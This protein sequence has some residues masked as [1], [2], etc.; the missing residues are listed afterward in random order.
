MEYTEEQKK[1]IDHIEEAINEKKANN[2]F[3]HDGSY[4]LMREIIKSYKKMIDTEGEKVFAD[5]ITICDLDFL[6]SVSKIGYIKTKKDN[7]TKK[8]NDKKYANSKEREETE[9]NALSLN[10]RN[11]LIDVLD[12]IEEDYKAKKFY[13]IH[14]N[15]GKEQLD[16]MGMFSVGMA[17]LRKDAPKYDHKRK[18]QNDFSVSFILFLISINEKTDIGEQDFEKLNSILQK[19]ITDVTVGV[20]SEILHTFKPFA[21]PI[22]N[23][24]GLEVYKDVMEVSFDRDPGKIQNYKD[25][26]GKIKQ[27]IHNNYPNY[28]GMS[29]RVF[30]L[31]F[32]QLKESKKYTLT[33]TKDK[34]E[35]SFKDFWSRHYKITKN[36]EIC[37]IYREDSSGRHSVKRENKKLKGRDLSDL[38]F[39]TYLDNILNM[40]EDDR[41]NFLISKDYPNKGNE[42]KGIFSD[43]NTAKKCIKND[44]EMRYTYKYDNEKGKGTF[45]IFYWNMFSSIC[46]VQ[47]CLK[48]FGG[49]DD[50]FVIIYKDKVTD[51]YERA[52]NLIREFIEEDKAG[53]RIKKEQDIKDIE[54]DAERKKFLD[55]FG[56]AKIRKMAEKMTAVDLSTIFFEK[57][58]K[59]SKGKLTNKNGSLC[60]QLVYETMFDF[61]DAFGSFNG[62]LHEKYYLLFKDGD[63]W[64]FGE[65]GDFISEKEAC[66]KGALILNTICN[67]SDKI[68]MKTTKEEFEKLAEDYDKEIYDNPWVHK[69][70]SIVCKEKL[71][72]FHTKKM[73]N[74]KLETFRINPLETRFGRSRQ[75]SI[76]QKKAGISAGLM[77]GLF[78]EPSFGPYIRAGLG[79]PVS[80]NNESE[81]YNKNKIFYGPPGTG[82]TRQAKIE[83]A[84]LLGLDVEKLETSDRFKLVQFH[85]SYSYN[86][87][88]ETIDIAKEGKD[89]YKDQVFKEFANL[90]KKNA[91]EAMETGD[92]P[93]P[94]VLII[95]EIN[96]ANAAEVLGE[97]LYA[98]EYRGENITTS[99]KN[100][101][102]AVPDNLYIFG[103][104]NTA[105]RSLQ[106]L[107]YA[108]RR[109]FAFEEVVSEKPEPHKNGDGENDENLEKPY[110][111]MSELDKSGSP[112]FFM[113]KAYDIVC[114]DVEL[115]VARGVEAK[116][117]MPGISYFIVNACRNEEGEY[118][119]DMAHF[120]YKMQYELIPLLQE[121]AKDGL[122]TRMK[123]IEGVVEGEPTTLID[124]LKTKDYFKDRIEVNNGG[125]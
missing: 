34:I 22:L 21:F 57:D 11:R 41:K 5:K 108:V 39:E 85:P 28:E 109:R 81:Y 122:F 48:K 36:L 107:D 67:I 110:Y 54:V 79:K 8:V 61:K 60:G 72:P 94:Y 114:E 13:N 3:E 68:E 73:L 125:K 80:D 20:V 89:K 56:V 2:P 50:K 88:M 43:E 47:E 103:T 25:S 6:Y 40:D 51:P 7:I 33:I 98:I 26:C 65:K 97:L 24:I 91:E 9:P 95:D 100:E 83:A 12:G 71:A 124:Y 44:R 112:Q 53:Q 84:T 38:A 31:A 92:D 82:K 58:P 75:L 55:K 99:I 116:S 10:E 63:H 23:G 15:N 4:Q 70:L 102:F 78:L 64:K 27:F 86:D 49:D 119:P 14:S 96:R 17:T 77:N 120:R 66:E 45:W 52:A 62:G 101:E 118:E 121:Y 113:D 30:D 35:H 37:D 74:E 46:F 104:M 18:V 111:E 59:K 16:K 19:D 93:D 90:A 115:S 76:I 1:N 123:R 32:N 117:I 29:Y 69:Y 106:N 87:F 42:K 105:D